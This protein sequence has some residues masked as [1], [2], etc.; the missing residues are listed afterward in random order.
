MNKTDEV[1]KA[2]KNAIDMFKQSISMMF[3][4]DKKSFD[5]LKEFINEIAKQH[6]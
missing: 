5:E 1:E 6:E 4:Q 3:V 2:R